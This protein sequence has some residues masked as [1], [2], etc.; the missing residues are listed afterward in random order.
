MEHV[1]S[2]IGIKNNERADKHAT[3]GAAGCSKHWTSIQNKNLGPGWKEV[4]IHEKD[5]IKK[6]SEKLEI[7]RSKLIA[8]VLKENANIKHE[9]PITDFLVAGTLSLSNFPGKHRDGNPRHNWWTKGLEKYWKTITS[10]YFDAFKNTTLNISNKEHRIILE[11]VAECSIGPPK[12]NTTMNQLTNRTKCLL[13]WMKKEKHQTHQERER[14]TIEKEEK[15]RSRGVRKKKEEEK[16][17]HIRKQF[18]QWQ[19]LVKIFKIINHP[20]YLIKKV[21]Q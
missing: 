11:L 5:R 6:M 2:H 12:E 19:S 4:E 14:R 20:H 16:L 3:I 18:L 21:Y 13:G 17:K 10:Q 9:N 7:R 8:E 1:K 15:E